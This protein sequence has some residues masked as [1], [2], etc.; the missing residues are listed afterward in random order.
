MPSS[1]LVNCY[2]DPDL[3]APQMLVGCFGFNGSLIQYFSLN[4]YGA[5]SKR[6]DREERKCP[7]IPHSHLLQAPN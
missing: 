7:N 1:C 4:V 6:H 5:F 2:V 3:T